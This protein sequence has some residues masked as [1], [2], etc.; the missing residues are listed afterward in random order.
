MENKN[1]FYIG[2]EHESYLHYGYSYDTAS[3][4]IIENVENC[5]SLLKEST[6]SIG[7]KRIRLETNFSQLT[8]VQ[9]ATVLMWGAS[10]NYLGFQNCNLDEKGNLSTLL[11]YNPVLFI[12][13]VIA[14]DNYS[15]ST[16]RRDVKV[17]IEDEIY[18][19]YKEIKKAYKKENGQ[20][21]FR[22]SLDGRLKLHGTCYERVKEASINDTLTFQIY[23]NDVV[24]ASAQF[25][26]S[27][28][29]F[30]DAKK[31][32]E[33]K[34]QYKDKYS[35][36][37]DAYTNKYDLIKLAPAITPLILTKRCVVQIYIQ[38]EDVVSSYSGGTYW[39]T[40]VDE[41]INDEDKLLRKYYFAKGPKYEEVSLLGFNYE[42]NAPF[43]CMPNSDCWNASS[44]QEEYG[45]IVKR[46]CSIK[47]TKEHSA[48]D[49]VDGLVDLNDIKLL[50][51][52]SGS[53]VEEVFGIERYKYDT[54]RI[55]IYDDKDGNGKKIYKSTKLYGKD[56]TFTLKADTGLYPMEALSLPM[57]YVQP[58]PATFN[59][60]EYIIEY[61]IWGRLLCDV[62]S[63][64]T[65][66]DGQTVTVQTYDLPKDDFAT[67]RR[68][69]KRCI[70]L[71]GFD[72]PDSL[73]KVFQNQQYSESPTAYG[74]NDFGEYF[75]PPFSYDY[76]YYFPLSRNSWAN[77][78]MWIALDERL[79][80]LS[81]FEHWCSRTYKE[82]FLKNSYHIAD[83][84]SALLAKIDPS[85]KHEKTSEYSQFLY[86]HTGASAVALGGCDLYIT[87]KT[88]ILKG[89]YDQ[90]AQKAEIEFKQVMDMLRD[91]FRDR[92]SVV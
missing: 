6:L 24:Y 86:G 63:Y 88:N 27:D 38:G 55:E 34:L 83:V 20:T 75:L 69:Y 68:N 76:F 4:E 56:S 85:I 28:C 90:A 36:I 32:V 72:K 54:Y 30:D 26:K 45:S 2:K 12:A 61:Q 15:G 52:G 17:T 29:K 74:I 59:L 37:L 3:G 41:Q 7:P 31:S 40:E 77:T 50:S 39:E 14:K 35:K 43:R 84:I 47:F 11:I 49:A 57:P 51:T 71:T 42:I 9:N 48:G 33:L 78:S 70:G 87:Q 58:E 64:E 92:K 1:R 25:N 8:N 16:D 18:P 5:F 66:E 46:P 23:R 10:G 80:P 91:C 44:V 82:Y 62:E 89:E 79:A 53:G 67:P 73:V 65:V 22:E 81:G 13:I 60:G 21:F 19:H